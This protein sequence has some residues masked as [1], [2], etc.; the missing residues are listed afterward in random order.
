MKNETST[1]NIFRPDRAD[2]GADAF[3]GLKPQAESFCPFGAATDAQRASSFSAYGLKPLAESCHPKGKGP[4][5]LS[6]RRG[7]NMAGS[8]ATFL[9]EPLFA[10]TG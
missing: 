1:P 7:S 8:A 5:D 10:K 3:L 6:R 9:H 4:T 2:G